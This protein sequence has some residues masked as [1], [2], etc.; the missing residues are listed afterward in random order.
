MILHEENLNDTWY[1][2]KMFDRAT[3]LLQKFPLR[4]LNGNSK[5]NLDQ[6]HR[7]MVF[8]YSKRFPN[9]CVS[10]S[11]YDDIMNIADTHINY[12][13]EYTLTK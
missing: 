13:R 6:S 9:M 1:Q 12:Y 4:F 7:S 11:F 10:S 2:Q 8:Y 3:G 5:D